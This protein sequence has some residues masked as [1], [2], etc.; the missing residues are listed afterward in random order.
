M[1]R[2]CLPHQHC[3]S[4]WDGVVTLVRMMYSTAVS[5]YHL[6]TYRVLACLATWWKI[7]SFV[8]LLSRFEIFEA[9]SIWSPPC[10]CSTS[11]ALK[12][13]KAVCLRSSSISI[14]KSV[15]NFSTGDH[16][17][18]WGWFKVFEIVTDACLSH[19][20]ARD[21]RS[22][23]ILL[24][25]SSFAIVTVSAVAES[26][27][28]GPNCQRRQFEHESDTSYPGLLQLTVGGGQRSI[29]QP[30]WCLCCERGGHDDICICFVLQF[31]PLDLSR[32]TGVWWRRH[33]F[34]IC[35]AHACLTFVQSAVGR[36]RTVR[37]GKSL[38]R[39]KGEWWRLTQLTSLATLREF[40]LLHKI[41]SIP[42]V[43]KHMMAQ[44]C[45]QC[46][47]I[48]FHLP[49]LLEVTPLCGKVLKK[50]QMSLKDSLMIWGNLLLSGR[51]APYM[52]WCI[53]R[54]ER[55]RHALRCYSKWALPLQTGRSS[56]SPE[57]CAGFIRSLL[58][59]DQGYQ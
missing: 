42:L 48:L 15:E 36:W 2:L 17:G 47:V 5:P 21:P 41:L 58:S 27:P 1:F 26:M 54:R 45:C 56:P 53:R 34:S 40:K 19:W 39:P 16:A 7:W 14:S 59:L 9:R 37:P 38:E 24:K 3:I 30:L 25:I 50:F 32:T 31:V 33:C 18:Y 35:C 28:H 55:M 22:S 51:Q 13:P 49:I 52:V 23:D 46:L 44:S 11:F 29:F 57:L 43:F 20:R 4:K 10:L 6:T 8:Y 12:V